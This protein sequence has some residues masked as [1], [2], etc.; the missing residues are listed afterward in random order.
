MLEPWER[1]LIRTSLIVSF[2]STHPA[3]LHALSPLHSGRLTSQTK[4]QQ[5]TPAVLV[6]LLITTLFWASVLTLYPRYI[7]YV[8]RRFSYYVF[9]DETVSTRAVVRAYLRGAMGKGLGLLG[10]GRGGEL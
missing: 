6:S 4:R 2:T 5:L 9:D 10:I 7:S 3:A 1:T 8:G